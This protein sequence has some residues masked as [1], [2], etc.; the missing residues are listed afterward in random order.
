MVQNFERKFKND[1]DT[2]SYKEKSVVCDLKGKS[3]LV[4]VNSREYLLTMAMADPNK[5]TRKRNLEEMQSSPSKSFEYVEKYELNDV[6]KSLSNIQNSLASLMINF[7]TQ[8]KD[9]ADMIND[10]YG[11]HGVENRLQEV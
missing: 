9:I 3:G 7:E 6:M 11:K 2:S 1:P 4:L 8:R 10:I 5:E